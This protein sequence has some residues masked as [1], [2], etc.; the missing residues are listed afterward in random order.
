MSRGTGEEEEE[1]EEEEDREDKTKTG[2]TTSKWGCPE[3]ESRMCL[4][5][6]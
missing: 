5:P 6:K 1:E 3:Q 2:G 4:L